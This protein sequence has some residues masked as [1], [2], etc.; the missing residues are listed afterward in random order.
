LSVFFQSRRKYSSNVIEVVFTYLSRIQN[1]TL[2]DNI[3]FGKPLDSAKYNKVV[4]AC[5]LRPDFEI[6]V[7]KDQT[8]IGENGINLSG[9]QKQVKQSWGQSYDLQRVT[10]PAL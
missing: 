7:A 3:L 10:M 2:R 6:L 4:D 1:L 5:A 9:G 8:E